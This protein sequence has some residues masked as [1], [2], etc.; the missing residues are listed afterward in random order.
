MNGVG[1]G[2]IGV[3]GMGVIIEVNGMDGRMDGWCSR[4]EWYGN[5][6]MGVCAVE[7]SGVGGGG[8]EVNGMGMDVIQVSVVGVNAVGVSEMGWEEM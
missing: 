6:R 7:S 4:R 5:E 2:I 8:I 3:S 1:I